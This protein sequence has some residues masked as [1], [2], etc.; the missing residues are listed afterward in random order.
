MAGSVTF[1]V[2][3]IGVAMAAVLLLV[4]ACDGS[5]IVIGSPRPTASGS[6]IPTGAAS[7]TATAPGSGDPIPS[8]GTA[9]TCGDGVLFPLGA[10]A[11]VGSAEAGGDEPAR[12]LRTYAASVEASEMGL[13]ARGWYRVFSSLTTVVFLAPG[14]DDG[15][16]RVSVEFGSGSWRLEDR[17]SCHVAVALPQG[18]GFAEWWIDPD[19]PPRPESTSIEAFAQELACASGMPADDRILP[20]DIVTTPDAVVVTI[21]VRMRPG[22][23]DCQGTAPTAVRIDL[24][25]P[26]G[27]RAL[28]DGSRF[29]PRVPKEP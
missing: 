22:G 4:A 23:Q 16:G 21:T 12:I 11:G 25:G 20:P 28:L 5:A 13:P 8:G 10:L 15:W 27:N 29:P 24:P 1:Q 14:G 2:R 18:I 19:R 7:P 3:R 6:P 9:M 26:L 17:G